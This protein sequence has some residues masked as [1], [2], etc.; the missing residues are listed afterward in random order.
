[1]P[2]GNALP[3]RS[4]ASKAG[5]PTDESPLESGVTEARR[6]I[7]SCW[8]DCLGKRS[9]PKGIC[10]QIFIGDGP[11]YPNPPDRNRTRGL[12]SSAYLSKACQILVESCRALLSPCA[13]AA[14]KSSTFS[15]YPFRF[16]RTLSL[17]CGPLLRT[18]RTVSRNAAATA[19]LG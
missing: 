4:P 11:R 7:R 6:A 2:V 12:F 16:G 18:W 1:M 15:D 14:T 5:G 10:C 9:K 19:C 3:E 8:S 17:R 13:L